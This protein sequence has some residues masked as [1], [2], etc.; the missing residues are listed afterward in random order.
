MSLAHGSFLG[1]R[2]MVL[3]AQA[4]NSI[5]AASLAE[6]LTNIGS[7]HSRRKGN[8]HSY[9]PRQLFLLFLI[10]LSPPFRRR[11]LR[12]LHPFNRK[13]RFV[14]LRHSARISTKRIR[15]EPRP[16][17]SSAPTNSNSVYR[18]STTDSFGCR[19][20][21]GTFVGAEAGREEGSRGN[22]ESRCT[23]SD[24]SVSELLG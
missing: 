18:R 14:P 2:A 4:W 20:V 24:T 6:N 10:Q 9:D 21:E 3:R 19:G 16:P 8:H 7:R 15:F 22:R 5:V 23:S 1:S 11:P 13:E 17:L 12:P